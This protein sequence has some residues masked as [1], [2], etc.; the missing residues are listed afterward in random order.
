MKYL[1]NALLDQIDGESLFEAEDAE[2]RSQGWEG[3]VSQK[4]CTE[5]RKEPVQI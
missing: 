3:S 4:E 2:M 5:E 1:D